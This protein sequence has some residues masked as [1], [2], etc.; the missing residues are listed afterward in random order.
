M[1]AVFENRV[2]AVDIGARCAPTHV[3]LST[4]PDC[5]P[6]P[7]DPVQ[8][9]STPC[10]MNNYLQ[11]EKLLVQCKG[12]HTYTAVMGTSQAAVAPPH[13]LKSKLIFYAGSEVSSLELYIIG[14]LGKL[15]LS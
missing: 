4:A 8:L 12:K 1:K 15:Y 13:V 2:P 11:P 5:T 14:I 10:P 7:C 3:T 9:T 6:S